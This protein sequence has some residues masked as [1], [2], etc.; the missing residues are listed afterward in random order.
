MVTIRERIMGRDVEL[1]I[2]NM[3]E[4]SFSRI[5]NFVN[6]KWIEVKSENLAVADTQKIVALVAVKIA[7]EL[8]KLKDLTE[9]VSNDYEKKIK[10]LIMQLNE[11]DYIN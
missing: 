3:N 5:V 9:S 10:S 1:N 11:V 4:L 6:E 7:V 8:F 2:D